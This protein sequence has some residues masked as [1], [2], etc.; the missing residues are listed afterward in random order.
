MS[1]EVLAP[2]SS[3]IVSEEDPIGSWYLK[4]DTR[5]LPQ[6][7]SSSPMV[8][9]LSH[10]CK[11]PWPHNGGWRTLLSKIYMPLFENSLSE[12]IFGGDTFVLWRAQLFPLPWTNISHPCFT[13]NNS[14][15]W[16]E[17]KLHIIFN[18]NA[19]YYV[20]LFLFEWARWYFKRMRLI[21]ISATLWCKFYG[22]P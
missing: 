20:L 21:L 7:C 8:F 1:R 12:A 19:E 4:G 15:L 17:Y 5:S 3:F 22:S 14:S 13:E 16:Q 6:G 9:N 10:S 18:K 2:I 11:P